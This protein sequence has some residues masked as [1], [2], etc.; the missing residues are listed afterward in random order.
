M[1]RLFLRVAGAG[2]GCALCFSASAAWSADPQRAAKPAHAQAGK[3]AAKGSGARAGHPT[4]GTARRIIA[5]GGFSDDPYLAVESPELRA[6]RDAERELFPAASAPVEAWPG[7]PWS[8]GSQGEPQVHASGLPPS[9]PAPSASRARSSD[10]PS[11]VWLRAAQ[12]EMPELPIRWD[13]RVIRYLEFFRDDTRGHA[14]FAN[15]YRRSGRWRDMMR[16]VLRRKSLP[17]DLVWLSMVESGFDV[18]ARSGGGAAGLWQFMPETARV[19][20]LAITHWIDE[21]LAPQAATEAAADF[22]AD[23]HRR[24]GSWDLALAGYNMGYAGLT[25]VVRRY[26]TNDFWSLARTEGT[27]PWETTLYVPKVLAAAVVA[28]NLAAFGFGDITVDP[29][30]LTDEVMVA[31]GTLLSQVAQ[32][33]GCASKDL[34]TLNPELRAGRTP[35]AADGDAPYAV[36]VAEG[37]GPATALALSRLRKDQP[38]LDHYVVRFGETLDQI[39]ASH[40]T[41]TQK[42]EDLNAIAPGEIVHGGT[43]VLVPRVDAA[44]PQAPAN[45]KTPSSTAVKITVVVPSDE[46]VYPDRKRVFYRVLAGDRLVEIAAALRVSTDDLRLWNDLDPGARLQEAMTLQAFV[47]PATDLSH[48]AALPEDQVRVLAVG[49]EE[50]FAVQE[51]EKAFR[52]LLVAAKA[53]ETLEAIG[54]RFDVTPRTMERINRRARGDVLNAGETVVVYVPERNRVEAAVAASNVA[55]APD[56]ASGSSLR[57]TPP[58]PVPDLLP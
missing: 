18:T 44:A 45:G 40:K 51:R 54:R 12:L 6:L 16:R 37:R 48:V 11:E 46:F 49:S 2:V 42:L 39:A 8:L 53:G 9:A 43:V 26:N 28:H 58:H 19:Y 23:L 5:G 56:L 57:P 34:E 35:P 15:L 7:E 27:L 1:A 10:S 36:R 31:P 29:P 55:S 20:G 41:T 21:R 50:F 4:D 24:F 14:T 3:P 32:A 38:P 30:V 52:R 22:L 25:S 13:D 17:E 47:A 33:A